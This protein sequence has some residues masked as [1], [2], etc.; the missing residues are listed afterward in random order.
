V[1]VRINGKPKGGS[2]IVAANTGL[3]RPEVVETRCAQW[4]VALEALKDYLTRERRGG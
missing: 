4:K 1:E 3:D 2:S